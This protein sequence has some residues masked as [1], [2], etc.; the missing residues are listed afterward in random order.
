MI[1]DTI[2]EMSARSAYLSPRELDNLD[3]ERCNQ[4]PKVVHRTLL[5]DDDF[6]EDVMDIMA[7]FD[8]LS[9]DYRKV[10]WREADLLEILSE[11][12]RA[13]YLGY[14]K[15]IQKA[16]FARYCILQKYGGIY[17]DFDIVLQVPLI[18]SMVA[19]TREFLAVEECTL[20]DE[21]MANTATFPHSGNP[22]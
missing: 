11:D 18:D 16:D 21:S 13:R 4:I 19:V 14:Q 5:Y 22:P 8:D 12:K 7:T 2:I 15:K 6:P 9:Q 20:S 1:S 17:A 10:L 3:I